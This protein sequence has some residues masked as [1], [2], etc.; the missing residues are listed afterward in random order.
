ML[1]NTS[2][3]SSSPPEPPKGDGKPAS[4][5]GSLNGDGK[6][7]SYPP[8]PSCSLSAPANVSVTE[9]GMG[10]GVGWNVVVAGELV[11]GLLVVGIVVVGGEVIGF[12]VV[13]TVVVDGELVVKV[14]GKEFVAAAV[15]NVVVGAGDDVLVASNVVAV[16]GISV[17]LVIGIVCVALLNVLL[18]D[19]GT[20]G[21][22]DG[23]VTL[24][25]TGGAVA[26]GSAGVC[27]TP[28]VV[29]D[30]RLSALRTVNV[31]LASWAGVVVVSCGCTGGNVLTNVG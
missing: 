19:D 8:E 23:D 30:V 28:S 13:D 21:T 29:G 4:S 31:V 22:A 12:I 2:G 16:I 6:P 25:T 15:T 20:V 7:P 24:D 26:L 27:V 3:N 1:L 14:I 10:G 9:G 17:V 5:V 11:V 18:V